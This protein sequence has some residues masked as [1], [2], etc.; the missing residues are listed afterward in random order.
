MPIIIVKP[1]K[2]ITVIIKL[3]G[4]RYKKNSLLYASNIDTGSQY[5]YKAYSMAL[6]SK[7]WVGM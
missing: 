7:A 1:V 3:S 6:V 4:K 2:R 5:I